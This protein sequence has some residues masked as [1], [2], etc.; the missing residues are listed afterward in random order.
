MTRQDV[1]EEARA[2]LGLFAGSPWRDLHVRGGGFELF[3]AKMG[4][5]ANPMIRLAV[6]ECGAQIFA[7][8]LG[9]FFA[10]LPAG[11]PLEAD[12]VIGQLEVLGERED[13]RAGRAGHLASIL[14]ADGVLVEYE[15]PLAQISA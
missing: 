4:G 11:A 10:S 9:L 7:P 2:M 12:T 5:S 15:T 14:V 3:L 13:V 8:H 1:V 6:D